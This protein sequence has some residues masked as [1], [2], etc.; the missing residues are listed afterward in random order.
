MP[1][2]ACGISFDVVLIYVQFG[3]SYQWI[4]ILNDRIAPLQRIA[5][6]HREI[7][8]PWIHLMA[9][10]YTA[11]WF[12]ELH[13]NGNGQILH[14][15]LDWARYSCFVLDPLTK[16][17][18]NPSQEV[19]FEYCHSCWSDHPQFVDWDDIRCPLASAS[20]TLVSPCGTYG[21]APPTG[22]PN[23]SGM[24]AFVGA[25]MSFAARLCLLCFVAAISMHASFALRAR[26]TVSGR[27][28]SALRHQ[29][30]MQSD[31]VS[32]KIQGV[33]FGSN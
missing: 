33:P 11:M 28:R 15:G 4:P 17:S 26:N 21:A 7:A 18:S 25:R 9:E 16:I 32:A 3:P 19:L 12:S 5:H 24:A 14:P 10:H 13:N 31:G 8:G 29:H 23:F 27:A 20:S 30:S 1:K 6:P 22:S 2:C